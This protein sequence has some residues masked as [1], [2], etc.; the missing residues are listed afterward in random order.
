MPGNKATS[1][2]PHSVGQG[3]S[4]PRVNRRDTDLLPDGGGG[5]HRIPDRRSTR[6]SRWEEHPGFQ[7]RGAPRIPDGGAHP[8]S[9]MEGAPRIPDG[10]STQDPDGRSTQNPRWEEHSGFQIRGASRIPDGG[11]TQDPRWEEHTGFQ[12][13]LANFADRYVQQY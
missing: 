12:I 9:Q 8:G 13:L 6:E 11:N 4:Q 10:G 2:W 3:K 7:I 1:L 5:A